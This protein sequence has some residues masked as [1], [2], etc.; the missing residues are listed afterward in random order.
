MNKLR[1]ILF[2]GKCKGTGEWV[3]G[4]YEH[5]VLETDGSV[6]S[7]ISQ[8]GVFTENVVNETVGQFT[9]LTDKNGKKIFEG[10]IVKIY[11]YEPKGLANFEIGCIRYDDTKVRFVFCNEEG[12]Y[13]FDN[14]N[15]YDII[16]NIHDNPEL[17]ERF[18]IYAAQH[19]N[20]L[21]PN[22]GKKTY[23][24]MTDEEKAVVDSFQGEKAYN[25]IMAKSN[26]YLAPVT[27]NQMLLLE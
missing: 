17:I 4:D 21:P 27:E 24:D 3:Q 19:K 7:I 13:S 20:W 16:G 25:E 11:L 10:D 5:F 9:G 23:K 12:N 8:W 1:E 26:Y 22:Y 18:N 14:T 2:R 6:V 15:V